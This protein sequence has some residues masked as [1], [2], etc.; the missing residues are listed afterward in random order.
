MKQPIIGFKND[1]TDAALMNNNKLDYEDA[2]HL[3]VAV[4][5]DV[6]EIITND[7]GFN[8]ANLKRIF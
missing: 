3:A 2:L 5:A 7:K 6:K 4:R 8:A 1:L